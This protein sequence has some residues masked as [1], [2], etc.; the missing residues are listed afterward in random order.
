MMLALVAMRRER[1]PHGGTLLRLVAMGGLGYVGQAYAYLTALRYASVG[2]V[3][4]LLYLYPVFVAFGAA[5]LYRERIT[6]QKGLALGL[7]L[8]GIALTVGPSGGQVIG[9]LLA[10]TA[11]LIYSVYILVGA[12][13]MK[14]VSAV[15]SS[16]VIFAAAGL[17]S[18]ILM[19]LNGPH[20]PASGT[21]WAAMAGIVLL[22]TVVPVVTFLA[23]IERVG[24]ANAALL[25]TL[26]PVVTVALAAVFMGEA[27]QPVV[28]AGG[29]LILLA[30][31]LL[32]RSEM[33][34]GFRTIE[35][36]PSRPD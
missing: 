24:P 3:A 12:D 2:L 22:A 4:L 33:Q 31:V 35:R 7:A 10:V 17:S 27:Q 34:T 6:L 36:E 8:A 19:A 1:L 21:G 14:Q 11:A 5:L 15:Q 32:A 20:M 25:S 28:L 30:V 26:E 29:G 23:G 18:G 9:A 13:V 16:A